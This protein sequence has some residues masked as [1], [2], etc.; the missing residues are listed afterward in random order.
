M[1]TSTDSNILAFPVP[2]TSLNLPW[3]EHDA[4]ILEASAQHKMYKEQY[5]SA[6]TKKAKRAAA[7]DLEFWGSKL[8]FLEAVR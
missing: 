1:T 4:K 6:V 5:D 7:E 3:N 2:H 8:A